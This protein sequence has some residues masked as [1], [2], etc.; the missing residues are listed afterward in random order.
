MNLS[1]KKCV[2]CEAG[3]VPFGPDEVHVYLLDTPGW[4]ASQD[5]KKIS[6]D[7]KFKDFLESMS[8][9]NKVA[10]IAESEGHHPDIFVSYNKV[11]LELTTHAS[12]GLTENDFVVAAKINRLIN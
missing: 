2:P 12:K 7:Y 11:T 8:F 6:K 5:S 9:V 4:T 3:T 1:D 10:D